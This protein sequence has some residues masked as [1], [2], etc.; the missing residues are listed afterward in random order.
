MA[1]IVGR[2]ACQHTTGPRCRACGHCG[3][4][5]FA[6]GAESIRV[7]AMQI[8]PTAA[9]LGP[10]TLALALFA[11][12]ASRPVNVP[13]AERDGPEAVVPPDL[14][15]VPDAEPKLEAIRK[16]GPNKPYEVLGQRY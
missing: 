13:T 7:A 3:C 11:G 2:R 15:R 5:R 16:G 4:R 8:R 12:C 14:Q 10:M 1:I 6:C 9:A